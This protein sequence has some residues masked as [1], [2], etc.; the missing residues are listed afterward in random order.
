MTN[1]LDLAEIALRIIEKN[2]AKP[3]TRR[4]FP[5]TIKNATLKKQNYRCNICGKKLDDRDFD[6]IDG[7]SSNN[8]MSNCQALC[9]ECHRKKT[10]NIKQRKLKLSKALKY[11]RRFLDYY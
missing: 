10:R 9:L 7:D 2:M 11:L 4:S 5:K 6:H 1:Y 8:S 3:T